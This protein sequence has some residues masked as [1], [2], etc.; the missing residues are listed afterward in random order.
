MLAFAS[1]PFILRSQTRSL[2]LLRRPYSP[3]S[4]P[5]SLPRRATVSS[6]AAPPRRVV[7]LGTP[8][9][10]ATALERI[11][12]ASSSSPTPFA[13]IAAVSQP[14]APSG[15]ARTLKP[16]PVAAAAEALSIPVLTPASA[17]DPAFLAALA[18]LEPDLCITA[19]YGNFLPQPFLDTPKF[20]TLNI[21]PSALPAFRGAAP[22]PRALEAGV[23]STAVSVA[24]TE[25]RMDSGPIVAQV[26]LDLGG[27]EQAPDVLETLF[28]MGTEA[29]I[30]A[31]PAV[32]SGEAA[33]SA[34]AQDEA[35]AS[36]APKIMKSDGRLAFVENAV[37]V[38]NK[39]RAFAG[40]PGTWGDFVVGTEEVRLKVIK[41]SVLRPE[42]GMCL[43]VHDV[44]MHADGCL[45]V[46]CDDGSMIGVWTVQPPGKKAMS[47]QAF[48]NGLRGKE[49]G[50]KRVP[51]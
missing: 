30:E 15:R 19:A 48:W 47:A 22:V 21:H 49:V 24:F 11:A 6:S 7:F 9:V 14:A 23:A 35:L 39:V 38:H 25:L 8:S 34:V 12:A 46:V 27:D 2:S 10:A 44:K 13:V 3:S 1:T 37:I 29:L 41:T 4:R 43:G 42:G 26:G 32:F 36:E 18:R 16:S 28:A 33:K 51:H 50:R 5:A 40:W 17:R 45:A 31:L 20:G